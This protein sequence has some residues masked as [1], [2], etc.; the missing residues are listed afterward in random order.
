MHAA[1]RYL[2]SSDKRDLPRGVKPNI[3]IIDECHHCASNDDLRGK[4]V[5]VKNKDTPDTPDTTQAYKAAYQ[6]IAGEFWQFR[7]K[8]IKKID[9]ILIQ[10]LVFLAKKKISMD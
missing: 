7:T 6:M 10:N 8:I 3:I 1:R 5:S 2:D 9:L 4:S